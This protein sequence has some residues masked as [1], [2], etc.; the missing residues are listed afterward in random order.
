MLCVVQ[1]CFF[2]PGSFRFS[3][4]MHTPYSEFPQFPVGHAWNT[5]AETCPWGILIRSPET[6][7]LDPF[8]MNEKWFSSGYLSFSLLQC[9]ETLHM[10]ASGLYLCL[11]SWRGSAGSIRDSL[12][13]KV[14]GS[15]SSFDHG[16][17]RKYWFALS[18]MEESLS[19]VKG[20]QLL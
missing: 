1:I 8:D 16:T 6:R 7:Q 13:L 5:S 9:G 10:V 12:Q 19:Q 4:R 14:W 18:W 11:C 20:V 2:L 17:A 15:T 3:L